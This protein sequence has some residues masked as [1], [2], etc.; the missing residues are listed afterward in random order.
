MP[1]SPYTRFGSVQSVDPSDILPESRRGK[2]V[3][4]SMRQTRAAQ[5]KRRTD[6]FEVRDRHIKEILELFGDT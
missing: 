2:R 5:W 3:P 1:C 4:V 6:M